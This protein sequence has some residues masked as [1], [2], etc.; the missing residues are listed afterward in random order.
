MNVSDGLAVKTKQEIPFQE[1]ASD[2]S[3]SEDQ[4][5]VIQSKITRRK[6]ALNMRK[7]Q[8]SGLK[9]AKEFTAEKKKTL[10][11]QTRIEIEKEAQELKKRRNGFVGNDEQDGPFELL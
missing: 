9:D 7:K 3:S 5:Q 1:P 8:S 11:Q 2:S 10:G 4:V 6:T